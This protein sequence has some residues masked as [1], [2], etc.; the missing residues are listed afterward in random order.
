MGGARVCAV[1]KSLGIIFRGSCFFVR[2]EDRTIMKFVTS[3]SKC[4]KPLGLKEFEAS[5][6]VV[7]VEGVEE[8]CV[9]YSLCSECAEKMREWMVGR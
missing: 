5:G 6:V 2:K 9:V 8:G 4:G 1:K 7:T 3:C